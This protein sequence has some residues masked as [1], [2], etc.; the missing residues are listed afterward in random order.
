MS[1]PAWQ[2]PLQSETDLQGF[3]VAARGLIA[4]GIDPSQV[5]W[6][7]AVAADQPASADLFDTVGSDWP[8]PRALPAPGPASAPLRVPAWYGALLE[9]AGLHADPQRFA[10]LYRLLWRLQREPSLR[11]DGLDPERRALDHLAQQVR[12]ERHKTKAFV[13]FRPVQETVDGQAGLLRTLHIA[14]FEPEHH[15]LESVA[16]FFCRRFTTMHW[17]VLTPRLSLRWDGRQ[18]HTGP[19]ASRADAPGPDAGE[20]LWLSYYQHTFNPARLKLAMMRKE[21]PRKYWKNLPEAALISSL[22][23]GALERQGHMLEGRAG[24]GVRLPE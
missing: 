5:S 9:D 21:M 16:P 17:A 8:P 23:A 1:G 10:R 11:H 6:H 12:R 7:P 3:R 13:R 2:V 19:G 22:A 15:T 24:P 20:A 18:L 14:W 4:A